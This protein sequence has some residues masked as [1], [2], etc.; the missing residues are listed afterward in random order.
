[1]SE[2]VKEGQD[3]LLYLD[4][5]RKYLIKVRRSQDFHTHRGYIALDGLIGKRFGERV[6]SSLGVEFVILKPTISDFIVKMARATQIMYPKDIGLVLMYTCIGSGSK[7]VEAGTGSGALT[8][9]LAYHVRPDGR[10][11]S[12]EIRPEFLRVA[13]NN[14]ERAGVLE[15]VELK[16]RDVTLGIDEKEVDAVILDLA[17]PWLVIPYAYEALKGGGILS[18]F[19]PT[20]EQIV[21]TVEA[22]RAEGFVDVTTFECFIRNI[23]VKKGETRPETLMIGHTGYLTFARKAL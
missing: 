21:K 10:V 5:R 19:S 9:A 18:S 13:R 12:Y 1:M 15:F 11:Y 17:T 14:L 4:T 8:A 3:I 20:F 2:V 7:V 23:K 16:N 22:L 6:K